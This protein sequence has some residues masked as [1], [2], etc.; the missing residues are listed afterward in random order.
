M[1]LDDMNEG[2]LQVTNHKEHPSNKAYKVFFFYSK[3]E[4][5]YFKFLLEEN[6][7]FYEQDTDK[8][9][10]GSIYL[11]GI[12]KTDL[13][14]VGKLNYATLGKFRKPI[15]ANKKLK[16]FILVLGVFILL[17]TFIS[18]LMNK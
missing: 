16:Y 9:K 1:G 7:I 13:K 5:D 2:F 18:Y 11:F 14:K 15:F 10:R 17:I 4:S 6:N 3:Q 8:T 12:R